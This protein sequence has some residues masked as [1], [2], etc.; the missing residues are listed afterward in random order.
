MGVVTGGLDWI[1]AVGFQMEALHTGA[2]R[3]L[4]HGSHG[5]AVARALTGDERIAA[6]AEARTEARLLAG[7]RRPVDLAARLATEDGTDAQLAVEVKVDSPWS[8]RQLR[9]TVPSAAHGVLLAVGRTRLAI[10]DIDM[11]HLDDEFEHPWCC[12]GPG[13]LV[14]IVERHAD[15]DPQ[16]ISYARHL[17]AEED[18][19]QA[20]RAAVRD[21]VVVKSRRD[22]RA[23]GH[24]AYF[25]ELLATRSDAWAWERKTL[26]S[27]PLVTRWLPERSDGA[28]DYL[29]FMGEGDRRSLCVKTY[30]PRGELPG[31][32]ALVRTRLD[33]LPDRPF[34]ETKPPSARAKTCTVVRFE[35]N[36]PPTSA[37]GLVDELLFLLGD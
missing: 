34:V 35:L 3:H 15:G 29:E 32:R 8:A 12:V 23:L 24:W 19:H 31:S 4:L 13:D 20:A 28:G 2:L 10:T 18:E 26:V 16:L 27:G 37:S 7:G 21:G 1:Q 9:E 11:R 14:T 22:P 33:A 6:V 36:E 17:R 5:V 30:A 25:G